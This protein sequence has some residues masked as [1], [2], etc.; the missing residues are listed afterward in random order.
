MSYGSPLSNIFSDL[1]QHTK[2]LMQKPC[3][4]SMMQYFSH[5]LIIA[6]KYGG[7]LMKTI[8]T[9]YFTYKKKLN[10]LSVMLGYWTVL[11]KRFVNEAF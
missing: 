11:L 7:I 8:S 9:Q 2:A 1:H 3:T 4:V 6:L 10:E 5:I